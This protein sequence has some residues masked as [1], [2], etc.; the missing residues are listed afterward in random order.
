MKEG[1]IASIFWC[2]NIV[3]VRSLLQNNDVY[4]L[5]FLKSFLAGTFLFLKSEKEKI[6]IKDFLLLCIIGSCSTF[7]NYYF[8][9]PAMKEVTLIQIAAM[10]ALA[11][12][13][14]RKRIDFY[15]IFV[16]LGC[17]IA[18]Q[19]KYTPYLFYSICVY[20]VGMAISQNVCMN[21]LQKS[22]LSLLF[23]S[24]L[25][26]PYIKRISFSFLQWFF[27]ILI[28]VLGYGYIMHVSYKSSASNRYLNL[29]PIFTFLCA[30]FIFGESFSWYQIIGFLF[31]FIAIIH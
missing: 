8:S 30:I 29:H 12:L 11:L 10:N 27:F 22:G 18:L 21:H 9:Y 5:A 6:I 31:V 1:I 23:G 13:I 16:F 7:L 17:I 19:G 4:T 26:I 2:L 14:P 25:F 28:S 15:S 3:V 20:G 24:I